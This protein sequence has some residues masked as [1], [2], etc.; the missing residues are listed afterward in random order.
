MT[1]VLFHV[2]D[3]PCHGSRFHCG[4]NDAH[5]G[6]DPR[7]LDITSLLRKVTE[8]NLNY[9]FAKMNDSTVKMI[10]EFNN[11]LVGLNGNKIEVVTYGKIEGFETTV[12][13]AISKSISRSKSMS[14]HG[15]HARSTKAFKVAPITRSES[16]FKKFKATLFTPIKPLSVDDIRDKVTYNRTDLTVMIANQPFEKGSLRFAFAAFVIDPSTGA[17]RKYVAKESMFNDPKYNTREY[18]EDIV[19]N[20]V[21]ATY[22]ADEFFK[23]STLDLSDYQ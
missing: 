3:A 9:F 15:G 2:A 22:L 21:I 10:D 12:A 4:V 8:L 20:Q 7:G 13:T 14:F 18:Y 17:K 23:I 6:G 11:E 16:S 5:P 1:R 19:E